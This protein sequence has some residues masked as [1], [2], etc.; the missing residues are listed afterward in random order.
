M[1]A[2]TKYTE[3]ERA[4]CTILATAMERGRISDPVIADWIKRLISS[5]DCIEFEPEGYDPTSE[6]YRYK[7]TYD[8]HGQYPDYDDMRLAQRLDH[9]ACFLGSSIACYRHDNRPIG[10]TTHDISTSGITVTTS[11]AAN[12]VEY[13]EMVLGDYILYMSA[14]GN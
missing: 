1:K 10:D 12:V 13:H 9:A 2:Q 14:K 7:S 5:E 6:S 4:A 8:W 3:V 11:L